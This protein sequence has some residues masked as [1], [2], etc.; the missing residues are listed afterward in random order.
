MFN[1]LLPKQPPLAFAYWRFQKVRE[2]CYRET[3]FDIAA[4]GL[5][6]TETL[7]D[8]LKIYEQRCRNRGRSEWRV[9]ASIRETMQR[10]ESFALAIK[11]FVPNDEYALLDIADESS[12]EDAVVRG[13]ELAEMAAKAKRVSSSTTSMQMAY[14]ALLLVY[15]YAYCMLF[16][17][18]IFPQII[19]VRPLDQWPELGLFLYHIDTF[20]YQCWWLTLTVLIGL[21]L[22]YFSSL[23]RWAGPIRDRFDRMLLWRNRRDL[24][25]ALL[26]VSLGLFDSNLTLRAALERLM[27]TADPWLRWHLATM[28]R[29][30]TVR[31]DETHACP[32]HR[33]LSG[34][35]RRHDHRCRRS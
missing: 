33:N 8:R 11:P 23:K 24:R 4:K 2:D 7:F 1:A 16:G 19:D 5:R 31:S 17:G 34:G 9:F 20:C 32:R 22:A 18:V 27:K 10:G 14:P 35:N 3:R 25:A 15:M 28:N 30:L 12:R 29:R 26:I 13:F 21:V 6:N